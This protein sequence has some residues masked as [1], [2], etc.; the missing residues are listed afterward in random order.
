MRKRLTK[1]FH[2]DEFYCKC[3]ACQEVAA[4]REG[5]GRVILQL[6]FGLIHMLQKARNIAGI[7][8]VITS[9]YRCHAHN[10]AVGSRADSAHPKGL[11][12]DIKYS[13]YKERFII[14]AALIEAGFTRIKIYQ[15]HIHADID[16]SKPSPYLEVD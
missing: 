7:P 2:D 9:G 3:K 16:P 15:N 11:A 1:N 10:K 14:V 13:G 4:G 5:A 12:V 8:F 6:N